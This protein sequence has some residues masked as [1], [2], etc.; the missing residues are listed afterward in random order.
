L[1][2]TIKLISN[3]INN[4]NKMY[5]SIKTEL[6]TQLSYVCSLFKASILI[7]FI[8]L[9]SPWVR[10]I[11]AQTRFSFSRKHIHNFVLDFYL[12]LLTLNKFMIA[13]N[14]SNS[15]FA[16]INFLSSI[17]GIL[18]FPLIIENLDEQSILFFCCPELY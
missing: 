4:L 9:Q 1:I 6:W 2:Y 14:K 17:H 11:S 3:K 7:C 18:T 5:C 16:N 15:C 12:Q 13:L 8:S 10:I